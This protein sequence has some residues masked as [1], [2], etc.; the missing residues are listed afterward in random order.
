VLPYGVAFL[1]SVLSANAIVNGGNQTHLDLGN[2]NFS[3]PGRIKSSGEIIKNFKFYTG[4]FPHIVS[5]LGLFRSFQFRTAQRKPVVVRRRYLR[6]RHYFVN[7]EQAAQEPCLHAFLI[8]RRKF[9]TFR[10]DF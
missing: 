8:M 9:R 1:A 4:I 2:K 3:L 7:R 6:H 5:Y 10:R